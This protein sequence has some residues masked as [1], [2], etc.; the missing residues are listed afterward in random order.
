MLLQMFRLDHVAFGTKKIGE[1]EEK[2]R[3]LGF[4]AVRGECRWPM[5]EGT[6]S[7]PSLSVMF[8]D[9]YLDVIG[10]EGA[11]KG[12]AFTGIVLGTD[13]FDAA[14]QELQGFRLRPYE[15]ERTLGDGGKV[16]YRIASVGGAARLPISV[17]HTDDPARMRTREA[18]EHPNGARGISRVRVRAD[19]LELARADLERLTRVVE[20]SGELT[21]VVTLDFA[22]SGPPYPW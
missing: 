2:L 6:Y 8:A 14:L 11:G 1:A 18:L 15:I 4:R 12:I 5:P 16:R 13:D 3:A 10:F 21:S 20:L 9:T 17:I 22:P 7:A 19:D